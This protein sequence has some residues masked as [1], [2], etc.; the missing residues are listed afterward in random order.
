MFVSANVDLLSIVDAIVA[1]D[2]E[3]IINFIG[4][5]VDQANDSELDQEL[6]EFA[7]MNALVEDPVESDDPEADFKEYVRGQFENVAEVISIFKEAFKK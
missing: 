6:L 5:I 2:N 1:M 4:L 3:D 7:K